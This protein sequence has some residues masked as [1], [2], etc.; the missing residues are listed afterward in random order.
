MKRVSILHHGAPASGQL[1]GSSILLDDGSVI[2]EKD[3]H[4]LAPV[5]PSKILATHLSY[6]SRAREFGIQQVPT[7]PSYAVAHGRNRTASSGDA[8]LLDRIVR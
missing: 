8:L 4:Y 7:V 3:A 6:R 1:E 5:E 2:A